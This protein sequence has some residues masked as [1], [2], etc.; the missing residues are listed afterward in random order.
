[1]VY[2]LNDLVIKILPLFEN[3]LKTQ[4]K[5][6]FNYFKEVSSLM[7]NKEHLTEE[8]LIKILLIKELKK[9]K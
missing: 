5:L 2:S 3:F 1:V 4:K 7:L 8:G 6:D 9:S